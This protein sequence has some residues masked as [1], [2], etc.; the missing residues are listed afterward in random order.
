MVGVVCIHTDL[1]VV[2][3][4]LRQLSLF[5]EAMSLFVDF[6]CSAA[7]PLF[8]FISGY[9]FS[10]HYGRRSYVEHLRRKMRT[11]VVPYVLWIALCIAIVAACQ[12]IVPGFRLLLH[13]AVADCDVTDFLWMFWD[14]SRATGIEA[15][16]H[17]PLVGQ[18]WFLQCLMVLTLLAPLQHRLVRHLPIVTLVVLFIVYAWGLLPHLPGIHAGAFFYYFLGA[19]VATHRPDFTLCLRKRGWMALP[20]FLILYI[21]KRHLFPQLPDALWAVETLLMAIG[22]LWLA[23]RII[24][25]RYPST[26]QLP[27]VV[28]WLAASSFFIFASHRFYSAVLTNLARSGKLPLAHSSTA[29]LSYLLGS[30]VVVAVCVALYALMRRYLPR[31]TNLLT[32]GR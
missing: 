3:P 14:V 31:T 10:I 25:R 16:Q 12:A 32:G 22:E 27:A 11:L 6:V 8:F 2:R 17:G 15:D 7:V 13:K 24:C 21:G 9:L 5:G 26:H 19:A 23:D 30:I 29:L 1:R 4:D 18:F 20:V 28:T